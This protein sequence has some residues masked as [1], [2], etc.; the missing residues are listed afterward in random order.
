VPG[1]DLEPDDP[2]SRPRLRLLT[3]NLQGRDLKVPELADL[4]RET[5][6]DI[7]LLQ[8]Y[9]SVDPS[10]LFGRDDWAVRTAGEFCVS[11]RL[12]IEGFETL[13][14]TGKKRRTIAVR[15]D[16]ALFGHT[17]PIVSV[18]LVTPRRGLEAILLRGLSQGIR[19]FARIAAF[20]RFESEVLRRWVEESPGSILLAGDF[21]LTSEHPLFRRDWSGYSD[22]FS[23]TGW[24][25]GH[26]MLSRRVGLRIDHILSGEGW[27]PIKCWVVD[28]DVGSAHRPVIAKLIEDGHADEIR[29]EPLPGSLIR[30]AN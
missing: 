30:N 15:A 6:P 11:S 1:W 2:P 22:A 13:T 4:I 27:R 12:P 14:R 10:D 5:Q 3:C 20:Q 26:T 28:R 29:A 7:V 24:G 19:D 17:L 21:N 9:N 23:R 18:H 16:V 25:L 8:E